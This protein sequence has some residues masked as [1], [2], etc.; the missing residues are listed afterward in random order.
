M[1]FCKTQCQETWT[2]HWPKTCCLDIQAYNMMKMI[3]HSQHK[4][5]MFCLGYYY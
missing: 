5:E 4:L 1:P 3:L 2:H